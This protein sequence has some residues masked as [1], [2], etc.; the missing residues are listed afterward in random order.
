MEILGK[1]GPK[2]ARVKRGR[3]EEVPNRSARTCAIQMDAVE[4]RS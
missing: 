4:V 2:Q 1:P 3:S